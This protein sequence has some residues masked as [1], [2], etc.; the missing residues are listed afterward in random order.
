M[1]GQVSSS[2]LSSSGD[3]GPDLGGGGLALGGGDATPATGGVPMSGA[4]GEAILHC[5]GGT[6]NQVLFVPHLAETLDLAELVA[7]SSLLG[8]DTGGFL[9]G[10]VLATGV[11]AYTELEKISNTVETWGCSGFF[12]GGLVVHISSSAWL[13]GEPGGVVLLGVGGRGRNGG[14]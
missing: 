13:G 12:G 5:A 10:S 7:L 6:L 8:A 14:K 4:I 11:P 2:S 1:G 9:R 3:G